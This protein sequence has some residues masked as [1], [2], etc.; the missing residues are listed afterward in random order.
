MQKV[1]VGGRRG[2][3]GSER[4]WAG[5][6]EDA[7]VGLGGNGDQVGSITRVVRNLRVPT[8][9]SKDI[10][11]QA[12]GITGIESTQIRWFSR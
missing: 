4:S 9:H 8:G 1:G 12:K 7:G 3:T 5:V 11:L 6:G 2:D 10:L